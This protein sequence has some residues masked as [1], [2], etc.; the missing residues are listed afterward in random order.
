MSRILVF[1]AG[2][3][4]IKLGEF[5]C[6]AEGVKRLGHGVLDLR[7]APLELKFKQA[8]ESI[9]VPI[10][11]PVTDDLSAVIAELLAWLA[12]RDA[13]GEII[14]CGHRIVHGGMDFDAPVVLDDAAIEKLDALSPLAPLHQPAG[15]RLVRAMRK[16]RPGLPQIACFDTAFH[17]THD[18]LITRMAIPRALHDAGVRRYGFHGLSYQFIAEELQRSEPALAMQKIVVAHLGSGASLCA[19]QAGISRDTSMGFSALD[20]IPM[21]TR[22]GELDAGVLLYLMQQQGMDADEIQH[23]L[24]HQCGLKGVSGISADSRVLLESDAPEALEAIELFCF[25]IARGIA[26]L[27]N[28]LSGLDGLVFTA[29]IGEHQPPI[30]AKVCQHLAWLG[31]DIDPQANAAGQRVLNSRDSR[32]AVRMLPTDEERIIAEA[33]TRFVS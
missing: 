11:A 4:T 8:G 3:S 22:P 15:L 20:G 2:S 16:A 5:E 19:L 6:H 33:C 14:A 7:L 13:G 28:T 12:S 26:A 24:Y 31:V 32:I 21:A 25:R 9:H 17:R 30:R 23:W 27:A 1:N 29:G 10:N 18:P